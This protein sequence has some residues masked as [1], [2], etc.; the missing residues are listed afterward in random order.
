MGGSSSSIVV[1]QDPCRYLDTTEVINLVLWVQSSS[2][3]AG[4]GGVRLFLQTAPVREDGVFTVMANV[5]LDLTVQVVSVPF[6]TIACANW[7]RW[8]LANPTATG[9]WSATFRIFASI[10]R[11]VSSEVANLDSAYV[12][13]LWLNPDHPEPHGVTGHG[14]QDS[15]LLGGERPNVATL[16]GTIRRDHSRSR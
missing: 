2:V 12:R 8:A 10:S 13:E 11:P 3:V 9:N 16:M 1:A 6:A 15:P 7:L 4:G 14:R 5:G